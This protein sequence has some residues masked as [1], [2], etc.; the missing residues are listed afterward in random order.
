MCGSKSHADYSWTVVKFHR[1]S[2]AARYFRSQLSRWGRANER[3]FPWRETDNAYHILVAEMMLRRTNA[4]QVVPTYL[5]FVRRYPTPQI[6]ATASRKDVMLVLQRLGLEWRADNIQ[7]MAAV[8]STR[9]RG[10]VPTTFS[11]IRELPGAGDYVASA[12]CCFA[13][14]K[15]IP[16][17]DANTVR[18]AGRYFGFET[19]PESR[20]RGDVREAIATITPKRGTQSYNWR[21]LDFAALICRP[22][23]PVCPSC[24][25]ATL[26]KFAG[27]GNPR[28]NAAKVDKTLMSVRSRR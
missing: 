20:R 5:E 24:P 16:I 6:L 17:V 18:V 22:V 23:N 19:H 1:D 4:A 14:R 15:P 2:E 25:V 8:L 21:L 26:C 11:G 9:F 10:K 7:K 28:L 13:F 3:R 12:V 27:K